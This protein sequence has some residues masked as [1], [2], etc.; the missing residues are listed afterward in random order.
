M[1][2]QR[3]RPFGV[4]NRYYSCDAAVAADLDLGYARRALEESYYPQQG[5]LDLDEVY[6]VLDRAL[7]QA[8]QRESSFYVCT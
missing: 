3:V 1:T 2:P 6:G 5:V 7:V 8:A 4:D